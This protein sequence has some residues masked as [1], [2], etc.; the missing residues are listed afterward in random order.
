MRRRA[1]MKS[2]RGVDPRLCSPPSILS[3]LKSQLKKPHSSILVRSHPR[4]DAE[5]VLLHSAP[6]V[7]DRS[8]RDGR[9]LG[10][11]WMADVGMAT[12]AMALKDGLSRES[13]T[14][15]W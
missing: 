8:I 3:I 9:E 1:K 12:M 7:N 4:P 13:S 11:A 10:V 6:Q 5:D 15:S 2:V 14:T